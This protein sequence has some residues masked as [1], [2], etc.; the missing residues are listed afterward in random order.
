M[1]ERGTLRAA[2]TLSLDDLLPYGAY[3]NGTLCIKRSFS[4]SRPYARVSSCLLVSLTAAYTGKS[5]PKIRFSLTPEGQSEPLYPSL[6]YTVGGAGE[7]MEKTWRIP[8]AMA[9]NMT[10]TLSLEL[11]EGGTLLLS[12]LHTARDAG[13]PAWQGGVRHNAHL[14]F[15][16]TAPEDTM[17]AF[18]MAAACG[19]PA[20]IVVPKVTKD[21]VF[22]C[23]HDDKINRHARDAQG[24]APTEPIFVCDLTYKELLA[25]DFGLQKNEIFRGTP[26]PLLSDFLD[27]CQKTGMRPMFSTHPPLTRAQW[28]EVKDMLSSRG[29][30]KR[31]HIKSF[32]A[33]NLKLAYSVFGTEIE[34]YT[35]DVSAWL[36]TEVDT[37]LAMGMDTTACRVGI[38]V[39]F[40]K[41]TPE[42]AR[43]IRE[44]GFFA[45]AYDVG[46][47]D[48]TEYE[49]LLSYGVSEFTEDFH[50]SMGL[51]C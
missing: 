1:S 16:G 25:Y 5:P 19:F 30:L 22:V 21:G 20:C 40:R 51:N 33:D 49:T 10:F 23:I 38:E 18:E 28:L 4:L 48:Y 46:M 17:P 41:Y 43:A 14:G 27:L 11:P 7:P 35:L 45:A 9:E 24:N 47:R 34:G 42:I 50:C 6:S 26:I 36:G 8:P 37:M 32:F 3:E 39:A 15:W 44:A 13:A 31:F 29:L 2:D 12:D